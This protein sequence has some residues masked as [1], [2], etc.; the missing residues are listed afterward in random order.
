MKRRDFLSAFRRGLTASP[1]RRE[2][3]FTAWTWVHGG[4]ERDEDEWRRRFA[5]VRSAGIQAVLVSGG[6]TAVLGDA[7][8]AEGL[9]FHRWTWMCNR[10]GDAAV[11]A[12][13]PEWFTVSREGKSSLT[14]PPYVGY[15]KWVCPTRPAVRA[16]LREL[17]DATAA[18]P[19]VDGVHLDYIRHC[20]VILPRGLWVSYRLVQDREYPQFDF[21]YCDVC[22]KTFRAQAGVDPLELPDPTADE[23]W[24]RFRWDSVTGLVKECREAVR[25]RGKSITAAVFPTPSLARRLVRQAWDEWG[26]D[27]VFPMLYHSFYLEDLPWIGASAREGVGAVAAAGDG[28]ALRAGLYIPSLDP[29]S[30]A[31]AV[32]IARDAGAQGVSLFEMDGLNDVHLEALKNALGA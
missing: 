15:Y 22:R 2:G 25:D 23:A 9:E 3:P 24:R 14:H 16:Y 6:D 12:A 4:A 27:G 1:I 31:E 18:D 28:T 8:H 10:N 5:R 30:L 26:L 7:A 19:R 32:G 29:D 13:H 11:Q 21:C 20:D 17:V